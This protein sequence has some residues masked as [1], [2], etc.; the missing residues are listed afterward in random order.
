MNSKVHKHEW[1]RAQVLAAVEEL[2]ANTRLPDERDFAEQFEVSR[3]TVRQALSSLISENRIYSVRGR[4]TFV[5]SQSIAKGPRLQSFSED[6][7]ARHL[8]PSAR[9]LL[10][11]VRPASQSVAEALELAPESPVVY[12]ERLRLADGFPM[13][14]ESVWLPEAMFPRL[15]HED[16]SR[17]LYSVLASRYATEVDRAEQKITSSVMRKR[18]R[19]LLA[20]K[21]PAA[22]LVVTRRSFD[23]RGRVVEYGRSAYR[24]DRYSFDMA[25]SR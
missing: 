22:A 1:V 6:M 23:K 24:S 9:L 18:T 8:N 17:S 21:A 16:L 12:M 25:I 14:L 5:G 3:A 15:L 2:P 11:E 7:R 10:A 4:G 20:M 19:D 13:C